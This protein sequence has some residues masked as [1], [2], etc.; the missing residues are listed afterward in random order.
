MPRFVLDTDTFSLFVKGHPRVCANV[1][2]RP[3]AET[4]TTII[5]VE[6]ELG[7]WYAVL[8]KTKNSPALAHA[9]HRMTETIGALAIFR[10]L[11]F[12]ETAIG[13]FES[14]RK[15]Y[16]R[17]GGNDLRIASI[18]MEVPATLVTRN[19]VDFEPIEGLTIVDWS[20]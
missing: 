17:I 6:E 13:R 12:S 4:T 10:L 2:G 14:L 18:A 7:G 16:P 11:S 20:L 3:L 8:R 15:Q 9:Y 1:L 19:R 5:T